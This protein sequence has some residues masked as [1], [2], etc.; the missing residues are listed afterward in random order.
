[1]ISAL[2]AILARVFFLCIRLLPVRLAGALGAGLGRIGFHLDKRHRRIALRNLARIYPDRSRCW[3]R[4]IA[5]ESFAELGRT[6]LELPHV[7]LR[8]R[9]FLRSRVHVEGE[10]VLRSAI[11]EG[12]GVFIA[13][14]HHSNWEL[15]AL[16]FSLLG[17]DSNFLYRP[18]KQPGFDAYLKECRQ[19]FG[20]QLHSRGESLRWVPESL[21]RRGC[22]LFMIDQHIGNGLPVPF[23]GHL[24]NTLTLPA[25]MA[26]KYRVPVLGVVLHRHGREF[27]FRLHCWRIQKPP[28]YNDDGL[29]TYHLMHRICRSFA[30][31]I[32][33]RPELWLW[34]HQ[35]WK[36]LEEHYKEISEVVHGTP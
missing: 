24:A 1:L 4:R 36:L 15:G 29:D 5:R 25:A 17:Y 3:R 8:S 28:E 19:R 16:M 33:Q 13:A 11:E 6:V 34:S 7:F 35:R 9:S 14:C 2:Q 12:R 30:P 21:R 27:R 31:V 26:L 32:H 23:L 20:A 22:V 10:D 18:L